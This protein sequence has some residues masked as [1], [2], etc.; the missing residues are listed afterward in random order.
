M[1]CGL[2]LGLLVGMSVAGSATATVTVTVGTAANTYVLMGQVVT[3]DQVLD[4]SVV[5]IGDTITCV[6][7]TCVEPAGATLIRVSS[8]YIVPGFIDAHN[9]VAYNVFP[10]W[11]PPKLYNN[12]YQW[13][14]SA[15]YKAF[16]A[17]YNNLKA[18]VYCE[19][20]KYGEIKA[21]VSGITT[22]QGTSPNRSCFKT[23]VRNVENQNELALP[24]NHIR[25][26][27]LAIGDF[28]GSVNWNDT[29]SFVVHVG[30]GIDEKSRTEFD[31]LKQKGLLNAN[32]AIIHGTGF[33][34][35]EFAEM[36]AVGAKLIWSP[37]SNLVLYGKTTDIKAARGAGV[38]VS[39]GVD[40]NPSGSDSIF[41][42]LRVA[43]SVNR[44]E[45]DEAIPEGDWL[46]M[47][48][49]NP[50]DALAV[51]DRIG[52]IAVGLKADLLVLHRRDDDPNRSLLKNEI[53]DVQWVMIGGQPRYGNEAGIQKLRPNQCEPLIVH[54][55][56]KRVCVRES[57]ST[58]EKSAQTLADIRQVL[59]D[60]YTSLA[61]LA[62]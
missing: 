19:M 52:R 21:L 44:E 49:V 43:E 33:G 57:P 54:G 38:K 55:S 5:V 1:R 32:T 29:K 50:A 15:S 10:K 4:G 13:Q 14:G 39:L 37:Q 2:L 6:G 11:V 53:R 40:W 36:A 28:E 17:P 45:F 30:E 35:A 3:P 27:I 61:P 16:K 12:R 7:D 59:L 24:G 62:P 25:T 48:T 42:E 60:R 41:D 47:V 58:V 31:A 56:R 46:K 18:T 22:I 51:G 9:H 20:V 26:N 23:L 8:A 34:A